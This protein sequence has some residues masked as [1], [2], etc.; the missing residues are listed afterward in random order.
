[1]VLRLL[2]FSPRWV[3]EVLSIGAQ[4]DFYGFASNITVSIVVSGHGW[5]SRSRILG[6]IDRSYRLVE[7]RA[8]GHEYASYSHGFAQI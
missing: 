2:S 1:M 5:Q 3:E 6:D 8:W 4:Y 7:A